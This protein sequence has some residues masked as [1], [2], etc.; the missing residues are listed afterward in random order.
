MLFTITKLKQNKLLHQT[1]RREINS[2]SQLEYPLF[3]PVPNPIRIPNFPEHELLEKLAV[4]LSLYENGCLLVSNDDPDSEKKILAGLGSLRMISPVANKSSFEILKNEMSISPNWLFGHFSY[5]LKNEEEKLKS[6][7][8]DGIGFTQMSFFIPES[9]FRF[10]NGE[11]LFTTAGDKKMEDVLGNAAGEKTDFTKGFSMQSRVSR[12]TY[13][14]NAQKLIAHIHRGDIYEINY[15]IEFF[16]EKIFL[17]PVALFLRLNSL[18]QAPFSALYKNGSHWLIC[19][20]PE[21]F[22]QK[23]GSRIISQPIKGTRARGKT[24]AEDEQLKSELFLDEKE[25]SENV[26]I[27]DLVRNDLSKSAKKG[28]VKVEELFGIHSFKSVHQMISTVSAELKN[29]VHPVDA[30]RNAF[31]MGSMTGTPKL[32]ALQL[33]EEFE[34]TKRGLYSGAVGYFTPEL[35]FDF[36]VV[37]R[38][39]QYNSETG[40]LSIMVGSALTANA[41]PE[42]EYEECLLKAKALFESLGTVLS[43]E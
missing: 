17:D 38:S 3:L 35:D 5:D 8:P 2:I 29:D 7:N 6:E 18:A 9:V 16:A 19:A 33:A 23:K 21:R 12:S 39:I 31:P 27:V 40:Y 14:S 41:D 13:I 32:A 11:L 43:S 15:C 36:N 30:I 26:M 10:E 28:T 24:I 20:S 1:I 4:A 34:N 25:R 42:K 22:L 37:I